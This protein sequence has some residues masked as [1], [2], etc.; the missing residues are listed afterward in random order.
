MKLRKGFTLIELLVVVA[1]IGIL[2]SVVLASL[3]TARDKA[4]DAAIKSAINSARSALEIEFID[5]GDYDGATAGS[6]DDLVSTFSASVTTNG[7]TADCQTTSSG[8]AFI[9]YSAL[10]SGAS[11]L[12]YFCV[13]STGF[14]GEVDDPDGQANCSA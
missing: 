6:C 12:G 11:G 3:N 4:K 1:I 14:A 9:Y 8:A 10:N 13:D 7:Q 5:N 2:A